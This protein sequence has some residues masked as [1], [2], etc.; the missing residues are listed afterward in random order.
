[1]LLCLRYENFDA[2]EDQ[3]AYSSSAFAYD[4]ATFG[5]GGMGGGIGGGGGGN[6]DMGT[7]QQ[8]DL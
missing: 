5:T 1:M 2:R 6:G 8:A 7:P 4:G 3:G